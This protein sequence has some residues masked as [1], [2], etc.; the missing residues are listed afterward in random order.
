MSIKKDIPNFNMLPSTETLPYRI[1]SELVDALEGIAIGCADNSSS[2][3]KCI[4]DGFATIIPCAP[5]TNWGFD[6]IVNDLHT[7][8]IKIQQKINENDRVDILFDCF[9]FLVKEFNYPIADLN[10]LLKENHIDNLSLTK[11]NQ[12]HKWVLET[13]TQYHRIIRD[14]EQRIKPISSQANEEIQKAIASIDGM[15]DDRSRKENVR[16]CLDAMESVVKEFGNSTDIKHAIEN[17]KD[18]QLY[19][20]SSIVKEGISLFHNIQTMYPDLRHGT[21]E[22]ERKEMSQAEAIYWINRICTYVVYVCDM[23]DTISHW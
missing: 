7:E 8:I 20:P 22:S 9:A 14:T 10:Q 5:T 16:R 23:H 2:K 18:S 3:I 17:L 4:V 19:G 11:T 21:M 13:N 12:G 6:F 15:T 1:I